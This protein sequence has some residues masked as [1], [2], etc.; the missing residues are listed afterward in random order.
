MAFQELEYERHSLKRRL[1][2]IEGEYD[3]R[4]AEL[5]NDLTYVQKELQQKESLFH[6]VDDDR[7]R[8][9]TELSEQNQR[10][11]A[12]LREVRL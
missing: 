11:T 5:Q 6:E 8:L 7:T 10:L 2:A 9:V 3:S 1:D 12:Q 4:L